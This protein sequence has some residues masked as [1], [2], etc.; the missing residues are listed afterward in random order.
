MQALLD[1][2]LPVF[3][4]IGLGYV[5]VWRDWINDSGIDGLTTFAQNFAI[6]LLLFN[7]ISTLDLGQ[8]FDIA[9]LFSFYT[10]ATAGFA[11]GLFGARFI[12]GRP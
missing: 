12:F 3:L 10:G 11:A 6:P 9:M 2:I 4:V 7:A 5:A 1:V 8:N